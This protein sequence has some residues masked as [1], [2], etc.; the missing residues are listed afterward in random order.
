MLVWSVCPL[1]L[2][3]YHLLSLFYS[4]CPCLHP[5][6]LPLL[7]PSAARHTASSWD[8]LVVSLGR[9][10]QGQWGKLTSEEGVCSFLLLP[11]PVYTRLDLYL[12]S[13]GLM[14]SRNETWC[15][16]VSLHLG[17]KMALIGPEY[18]TTTR[19]VAQVVTKMFSVIFANVAHWYWCYSL[20]LFFK[21]YLS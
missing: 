15:F 21:M 9:A 12:C 3:C 2:V 18:S 19:A 17:R 13:L 11:A 20:F 4:P 1:C 8:Q 10:G 16:T 5:G 14:W 6:P 7:R